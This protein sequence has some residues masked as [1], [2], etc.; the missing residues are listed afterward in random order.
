MTSLPGKNI[1]RVRFTPESMQAAAVLPPVFSAALQW[2]SAQF[3]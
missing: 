2:G 3:I 1:E